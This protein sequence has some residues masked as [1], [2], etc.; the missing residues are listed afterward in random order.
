MHI[1]RLKEI[2]LCLKNA[3]QTKQN[4]DSLKQIYPGLRQ[5]DL[6]T[7]EEGNWLNDVIINKYF[8]LLVNAKPSTCCLSSFFFEA[9]QRHG[10]HSLPKDLFKKSHVLIPVCLNEHWSLFCAVPSKKTVDIYNSMVVTS[11]EEECCKVS[12]L[13]HH[14]LLFFK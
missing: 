10:K 4:S 13:W 12:K 3:K 14:I 6:K 7:L 8:A 2:Q 9:L 5:L 11:Q 1:F